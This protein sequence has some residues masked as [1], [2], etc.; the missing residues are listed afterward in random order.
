MRDLPLQDDDANQTHISSDI[1]KM[2]DN[3]HFSEREK[4]V[5]EL[6]L[7]GKSNKQ[8]ALALGI[9]VSTV[10]YH[11]KNVYRKLQVN[12]R[13]EAVLRLGKSIGGNPA[14]KLGEST[15]E[16]NGETVNND[17][18]PISIR[19][20]PMNKMFAIISGGIL[21][22][23]LVVVLILVNTPVQNTEVPPTA[24]ARSTPT[25]T[26]MPTLT[27]IDFS[28]STPDITETPL[29]PFEYIEYVVTPD[30]TCAFIAAN[31]NVTV[32][33]IMEKNN[34]SS[35]CLLTSGQILLIPLST[36]P[37][38]LYETSND[39]PAEFFGEWVNA[40]M[41]TA[42][43]TRVS[44]QMKNGETHINMFG[45]CQPTDCNFLEYAPT[46]TVDYNYDSK[47]GIL[48]VKWIFDFE[49]LTQ[50]ATL[51]SDGLLKVTTQ[52]HYLDNSGRLDFK[53]VEY[54]ARQ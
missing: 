16:I 22:I 47:S 25:L 41:S 53:T 8:I 49:T 52:N 44:I 19:R 39:P 12:S 18:Q 50:E 51:T 23:A 1:K 31:F 29:P 5:T 46:P 30:D 38:H 43:M 21:T 45:S 28:T 2:S 15:V 24:Q 9:S 26:L 40:D 32:E 3:G 4:E 35:A 54:F 34:L 14:D 7:Q 13:T 42:N 27:Q 17:V 33:A 20:I 48:N 6:L 37:L 36:S 10:E 11:L